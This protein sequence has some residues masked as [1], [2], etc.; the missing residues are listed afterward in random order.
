VNSF[1]VITTTP[2][3]QLAEAP[4]S[5][6]METLAEL[7]KR[8]IITIGQTAL[9]F[10]K[11]SMAIIAIVFIVLL[12]QKLLT[13]QARS[14]RLLGSMQ[15]SSKALQALLRLTDVEDDNSDLR[16]MRA[17]EVGVEY[18]EME[19]AVYLEFQDQWETV[20]AYPSHVCPYRSVIEDLAH[21]YP[22]RPIV[23]SYNS[24]DADIDKIPNWLLS[25]DPKARSFA[26]CPIRSET[27]RPGIA[28]FYCRSAT[29]RDF[30]REE[31]ELLALLSQF[32]GYERTRSESE[33]EL[34]TSRSR[35]SAFITAIDDIACELDF[36]GNVLYLW[37]KSDF[38]QKADNQS[39][40]LLSTDLFG[41]VAASKFR[42]AIST[43]INCNRPVIFEF[44]GS[45]ATGDKNYSAR[46]S[47]SLAADGTPTSVACLI[48]ET[49][50]QKLTELRFRQALRRQS[51]HELAAGIANEINDPLQ[52]IVGH[53]R[54]IES[55]ARESLAPSLALQHSISKIRDMST[56]IGS[57]VERLDQFSKDGSDHPFELVFLGD[58]IWD[59]YRMQQARFQSAD[60]RFQL[61]CT[62][63]EDQFIYCQPNR[64]K[65]A[66][67][68]LCNN[69]FK[70]V[71][72][73]P[74][75]WVHLKASEVHD[76]IEVSVTDSG[77]FHPLLASENIDRTGTNFH[78]DVMGIGLTIC[79][80][81]AEEHRGQIYFDEKSDH[82]RIVMTFPKPTVGEANIAS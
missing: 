7:M 26:A 52:V 72:G 37:S 10:P 81:I 14:L 77:H 39:H 73:R 60:I 28:V 49:T 46:V 75:R 71:S 53:T 54:R 42:S 68:N 64:V 43:A 74:L 65:E 36:D 2:N 59:V 70:A 6:T 22:H 12:F 17:L 48:R 29:P 34:H 38:H 21:E 32:M 25:I 27:N 33:H 61:D 23:G 82:T 67:I 66:L 18:F 8:L 44:H 40:H 35:M 47:P 19:F 13:A 50:Q 57:I 15:K 4:T 78:A 45:G 41:E 63:A 5:A 9:E 24:T 20:L 30:H 55:K 31:M 16:L 1:S 11:A 76:V 79:Q 3:E 80:Q 56:R 62:V 51:F 69:S 58:I